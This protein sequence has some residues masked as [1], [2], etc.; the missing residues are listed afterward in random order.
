M[1]T[2]NPP[3]NG[4]N[5]SLPANGLLGRISA[6]SAPDSVSQI[7]ATPTSC[8]VRSRRAFPESAATSTLDPYEPK[9]RC[10]WF[11]TT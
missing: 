5:P 3:V 11:P 1:K 2:R 9:F 4:V 8:T 6:I 7:F 10:T